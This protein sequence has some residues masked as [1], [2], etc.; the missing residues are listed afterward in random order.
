M[1]EMEH[2][3][4]LKRFDEFARKRYGSLYNECTTGIVSLIEEFENY[5]KSKPKS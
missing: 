2:K 4:W 3:E 5:E 1:T